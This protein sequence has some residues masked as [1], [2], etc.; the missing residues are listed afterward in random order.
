VGCAKRTPPLPPRQLRGSKRFFF[1]K[2]APRPG[3]Q[4]TF[5]PAGFGTAAEKIHN[6]RK[7]FAS[8]GGEP[9]FKKEAL[10]FSYLFTSN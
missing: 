1:K 5:A 10:P 8:L 2:K 9:F 4:K 7:F 6:K 3:K